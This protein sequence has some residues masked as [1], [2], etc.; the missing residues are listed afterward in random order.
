MDLKVERLFCGVD[1]GPE[2]TKVVVFRTMND[3]HH[4][5]GEFDLEKKQWM[6][7][8]ELETA[9]GAKLAEGLEYSSEV[10]EAQVL[11]RFAPED[12][13]PEGMYEEEGNPCLTIAL[14]T[15][16]GGLDGKMEMNFQIID[17]MTD[18]VV[19]S[20]DAIDMFALC[21]HSEKGDTSLYDEMKKIARDL[22]VGTA[23]PEAL[24][25]LMSPTASIV[26]YDDTKPL[27]MKKLFETKPENWKEEGRCPQ[28]GEL[29]RY[30]NL[31][32][33]CSKH[34]VY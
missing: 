20:G 17:K 7:K 22:L 29:G 9:I 30:I 31:A 1:F 12:V 5:I 13:E 25:R 11:G 19:L 8:E 16:T 27:N 24:D 34:G 2:C 4:M 33:T 10:A 15:E 21:Y 3:V 32:P 6:S 28:C 23:S 18:E 14:D 26:T